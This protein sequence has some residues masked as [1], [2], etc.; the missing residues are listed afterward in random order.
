MPLGDA[1]ID[2][3]YPGYLPY[4]VFAVAFLPGALAGGILGWFLI[5]PVNYVLGKIFRGF[6][7]IFDKI[8][9]GYGWTIGHG[10]RVCVLILFVYVALL[11]AT[12]WSMEHCADRIYS[13]TRSGLFARECDVARLGIPATDP[14]S[15][16]EAGRDS[17]GG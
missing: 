17:T 14:G 10:L 4:L 5:H 12:Y 7:V 3:V 1:A 11:Y 15:D 2:A 16:G 8:T 13:G 9:I 6:N